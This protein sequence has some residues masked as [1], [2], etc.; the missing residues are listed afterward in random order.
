MSKLTNEQW[1][2]TLDMNHRMFEIAQISIHINDLATQF[3]PNSD[4]GKH[5]YKT[6]GKNIE[7]GMF[8]AWLKRIHE[9]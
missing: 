9:K 2:C 5:L 4:M 8:D 7:Q 6:Y 1:L 3:D